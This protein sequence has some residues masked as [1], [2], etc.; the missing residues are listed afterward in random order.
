MRFFNI[1]SEDE[2]N[3]LST[4]FVIYNIIIHVPAKGKG[5]SME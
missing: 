2:P 4:L 5:H 3:K 1:D